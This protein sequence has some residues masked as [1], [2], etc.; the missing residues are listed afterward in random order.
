MRLFESGTL[1]TLTLRNR[2]VMPPMA[3]LFGGEGGT[4]SSRLLAYYSRRARGGAGLIIVENTAI[5]PRGI[6]Y[7]GTLEIHSDRFE[8]GL[9]RL[10]SSI[11]DHGAAAAIQLFHPGRQMHPKYAGNYPVAPSPIPCPVMG[12]SPQVL[13]VDEIRDL[14]KRFVAGA[15]RAKQ[16]GFDA[17]EIHGAHGYLVAQFLSPFSNRRNDQYG[18]DTKRRV[19]FAV[20]IV[21]GIRDR[22]G[23]AFPVLLRISADEKVEGGLTLEQ[24]RELVPHLENAG[25]TALH[26][27]A[28]CYPSMEW[29]VQPYFQPQ[30]C[31]VELAAGIRDVTALPILAVGRINDPTLAESILQNGAADFVS[32]GRAL[33]ADPDLPAKARQGKVQ[34]IRPC[35]ACNV[36]IEAVGAKQTRCAVNPEMGREDEPLPTGHTASRILVVGGGPAGIETALR[37]HALG[38]RVKLVEAS[39]TLGGQLRLAAVPESKTTMRNLLDHFRYMVEQ[40][41]LE[42]ELGRPFDVHVAQEFQPDHVILATGAVPRPLPP[43]AGD[44]EAGVMQAVT[45]LCK[46][47]VVKGNVVVVGGGLVGLDVAEFLACQGAHVTIMEMTKQAGRE[48]QWHVRKMK[49]DL[50]TAKGVTVRTGSRVTRIAEGAIVFVDPEGVERSLPTDAVVV[51]LGSSPHNPC[52]EAVRN[53][54]FRVTRI[55]DCRESRD[56]ADAIAEGFQIAMAYGRSR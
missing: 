7:T 50:L 15:V 6:N 46:A 47:I 16:V 22:L 32:M 52:E 41:G 3:T 35:I 48:L 2:I 21:E 13:V 33:M 56:L 25:V 34:E 36:C 54:D 20:E 31:L 10:A 18:G 53:M 49:L 4:V 51:A 8:E 19:R 1:G 44:R 27:S 14:V 26:V 24:T 43:D 37:A 17:V 30:G 12:G 9:A 45:V 39:K 38:H 23:D 29:V 42:L 55:G 40:S 5:H 28:G 11:K